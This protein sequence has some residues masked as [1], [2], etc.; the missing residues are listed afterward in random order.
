MAPPP[1]NKLAKIFTG[2]L[3]QLSTVRKTSVT[4]DVIDWPLPN[5][6]FGC[7]TAI[8]QEINNT[9]RHQKGLCVSAN[10]RQRSSRHIAS[11]GLR[12]VPSVILTVLS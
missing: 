7:A 8:H 4:D 12:L 11:M 6:I 5:K 9:S 10:E 1:R 3:Y 2:A